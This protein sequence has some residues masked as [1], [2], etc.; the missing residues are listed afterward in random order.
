MSFAARPAEPHPSISSGSCRYADRF[1]CRRG[2][3]AHGRARSIARMI[4]NSASAFGQQSWLNSMR[5]RLLIHDRPYC[6]GGG[7]GI[8]WVGLSKQISGPRDHRWIALLYQATPIWSPRATNTHRS[9]FGA[10]SI[11]IQSISARRGTSQWIR[12][13]RHWPWWVS[14]SSAMPVSTSPYLERGGSLR[15]PLSRL[16]EPCLPFRVRRG[17][18]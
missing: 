15:C 17:R 11:G 4:V 8:Q 9:S 12:R 7:R 3:V 16:S 5:L 14:L 1:L 6:G 13:F 10:L 2:I 18:L